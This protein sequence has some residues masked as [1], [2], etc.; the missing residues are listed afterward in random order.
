MTTCNIKI[1]ELLLQAG[2]NL[3]LK[4]DTKKTPYELLD[5]QE[6]NNKKRKMKN[7]L[8]TLRKNAESDVGLASILR[9]VIPD[10][11]NTQLVWFYFLNKLFL[12]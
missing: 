3:L 9:H 4:D 10:Q 5:L 12:L 6:D 7:Y 1:V 2:G 11:H 8:L